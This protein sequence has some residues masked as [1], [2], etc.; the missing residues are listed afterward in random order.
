MKIANISIALA[1][2]AYAVP[3]IAYSS[4]NNNN[5]VNNIRGPSNP[6]VSRRNLMA[7]AGATAMLLGGLGINSQKA[8]A[9]EEVVVAAAEDT[10]TPLYFGVGVSVVLY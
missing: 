5:N 6:E 2:L 9:E 3:S 4:N 7:Q 1:L 8:L 10:L